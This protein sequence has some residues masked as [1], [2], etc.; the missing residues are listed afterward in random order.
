MLKQ[1]KVFDVM[2]LQVFNGLTMDQHM[3]AIHQSCQKT[4]VKK[5]KKIKL[6]VQYTASF[7]PWTLLTKWLMNDFFHELTL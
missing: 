6:Y 7:D 4:S 2:F 1:E 5:L 3:I